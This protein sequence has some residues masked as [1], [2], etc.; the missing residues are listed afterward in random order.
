[1]FDVQEQQNLHWVQAVVGIFLQ[2]E[3]ADE[4]ARKLDYYIDL[5]LLVNNNSS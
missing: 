5:P 3:N 4:L 2:L 1:M